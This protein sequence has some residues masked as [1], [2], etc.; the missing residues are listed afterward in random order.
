MLVFM[1]PMII[2][3]FVGVF[4]SHLVLRRKEAD[5]AAAAAGGSK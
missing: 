1:A 4:V 2:L 3:Y 5:A